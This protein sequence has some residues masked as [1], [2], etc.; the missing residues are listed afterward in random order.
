MPKDLEL[1]E[2]VHPGMGKVKINKRD[3]DMWRAKGATLVGEEPMEDIEPAGEEV[4]VT[5]I[6]GDGTGEALPEIDEEE[7]TEEDEV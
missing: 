2:I 4:E 5:E 7:V 3:L 1:I 6:T